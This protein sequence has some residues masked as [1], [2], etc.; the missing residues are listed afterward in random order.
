M[1]SLQ[2]KILYC[3]LIVKFGIILNDLWFGI[4]GACTSDYF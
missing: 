4:L 2:N 3:C 1:V